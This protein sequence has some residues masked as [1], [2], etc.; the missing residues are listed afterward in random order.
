MKIRP[1]KY[2]I[3]LDNSFILIPKIFKSIP[4]LAGPTFFLSKSS[5]S[6]G[7][8]VSISLSSNSFDKS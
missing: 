5:L 3:P 7:I 2:F 6:V 8:S 1:M 4:F